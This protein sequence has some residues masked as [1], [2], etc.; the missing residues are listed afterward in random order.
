MTDG[1]LVLVSGGS[2]G[3]GGAVVRRAAERGLRPVIGYAR[4]R[5]KAEILAAETSGMALPL[6]LADDEAIDAGVAWAKDQENPL[7]ALVLAASPPPTLAAFGKIAPEDMLRQW[8]ISVAGPQRLLAGLVKTCFRKRKQG[9]VVG[10]LSAAMGGGHGRQTMPNM[11]AYVIAKHGLKGLLELARAEYPWLAVR[12][13]SPGFTETAMLD[14]FDPRFL[15]LMRAQTP[16][17]RFADPEEVALEIVAAIE[18][19]L[20]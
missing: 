7:A 20:A 10:V 3:I 6:D 1:G 9:V 5:E 19:G 16:K 11:G 2:G 13:V 18:A 8:R 14:A 4:H 12:T 17:G 15:E